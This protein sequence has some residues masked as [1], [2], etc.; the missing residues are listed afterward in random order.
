MRRRGPRSIQPSLGD[1]RSRSR[2]NVARPNGRE[3]GHVEPGVVVL[4]GGSGVPVVR[5]GG[6]SRVSD[7]V[8]RHANA[9]RLRVS[10]FPFPIA[11]LETGREPVAPRTRQAH[12]FCCGF[13]QAAMELCPVNGG[14]NQMATGGDGGASRNRI[15]ASQ[16]SQ[17]SRRAGL[18]RAIGIR[19]VPS[20][21]ATTE[22]VEQDTRACRGTI[23]REVR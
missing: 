6:A 10:G 3:R 23:E 9:P 8:L 4:A 17:G 21:E 5:F 18:R 19:Y 12:G 13:K 14:R 2:Q 1:A 20:P 16:R 15:A 11:V 22:A 7:A